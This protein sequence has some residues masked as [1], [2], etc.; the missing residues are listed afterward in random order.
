MLKEI[1]PLLLTLDEAPNIGRALDQL[2][3][4]RE[5]VVLD[6]DSTDA[7]PEIVVRYSNARLVQRAFDAH[8]R[9][10][11]FGLRQTGITS[12]WVLAL[13]AD[14]IVTDALIAEIEALRPAPDVV[15]YT[16]SF[17][18]CIEGKPLGSTA[19][20]PVTVLFR[21]QYGEYRQDGHTQRVHLEGKVLA[22]AQPI[23]H[24]DRKP[25]HRWIGSQSRYMQLESAKLA[26]ARFSELSL[27]DKLRKCIVIAPLAMFFYCMIIKKNILDGRAGLYYA[28][29]RT[30]AELILSLYLLHANL[31]R[32]QHDGTGK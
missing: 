13:D 26:Q 25:L 4:A 24:D 27:Q 7:T 10:W 20:P 3:W 6:S 12:E 28:L 15:G 5:I 8:A 29:Q 30:A 32:R 2:A 19:Y 11:N 22:L 14:Y 1:T 17:R 23:L 9:Q 21:R 16:A 18:Y 31:T